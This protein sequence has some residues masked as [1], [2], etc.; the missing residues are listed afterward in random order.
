MSGS[1]A[2]VEME[3]VYS[4]PAHPPLF[5]LQPPQGIQRDL[6]E[7]V[8][9][10]A[11]RLDVRDG[12]KRAKRPRSAGDT[13]KHGSLSL[14]SLRASGRTFPRPSTEMSRPEQRPFTVEGET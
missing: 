14:K 2:L 8:P 5:D 12:L 11:K 10:L 13:P 9:L 3:S 7:G 1:T 6:R 4:W